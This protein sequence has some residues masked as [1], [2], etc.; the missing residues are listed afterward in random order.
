MIAGVLEKADWKSAKSR[1]RKILYGSLFWNRC[2]YAAI[3]NPIKR[4]ESCK[5][6]TILIAGLFCLS[7]VAAEADTHYLISSNSGSASPYTS[8]GT[9]GTSVIDVVNAAMSDGVAPRTVLA[10]NGVYLLTNTVSITNA[11]AL[12]GVNG[13]DATIMDGTGAYRCFILK[14]TNSVIDNL[15]I[16]NGFSTARGGGVYMYSG[17]VSNCLITCC[18]S[19]NTANVGGAGIYVDGGTSVVTHCILRLNK[20]Y[21]S[22]GQTM[23]GG[24]RIAGVGTERALI[25]NCTIE[26]N[27]VTYDQGGGI[28]ISG[29]GE[30]VIRNCLISK[31][32]SRRGGGLYID[33]TNTHVVNCTIIRNYASFDTGGIFFG[34][35]YTNMIVNCIVSSNYQGSYIRD[36]EGSAVIKFNCC[37]NSCCV[38]SNIFFNP[39]AGNTTNDPSFLNYAE[40]NYRFNRYSPCYNAGVNQDWM[41]NAV[42]LDGHARILHGRADI[43]AFE[44]F[45]PSGTMFRVR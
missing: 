36:L 41:A 7:I 39:T 11:V 33:N 30:T 2:V 31:N 17:V 34:V 28:Y 22:Y 13:R 32:N 35:C 24:I 14:H 38:R 15:T 42:D 40:G 29:S 10:S 1:G 18:V 23:G 25:S 8:W 5:V 4:G 43:G 6:K 3:D 16:T 21:G 26:T 12:R 27:T 19:S 44:L 45:I 9:A 20:A 37:T